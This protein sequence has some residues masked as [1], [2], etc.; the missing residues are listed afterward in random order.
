MLYCNPVD[1]ITAYGH[2]IKPPE[3]QAPLLICIKKTDLVQAA[4]T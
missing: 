4:P 1:N 3:G 2:A